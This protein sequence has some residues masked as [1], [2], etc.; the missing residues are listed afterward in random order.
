MVYNVEGLMSVVKT[1]GLILSVFFTAFIYS[2]KITS[3]LEQT[4]V[5]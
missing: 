4:V 3:L 1:G 2:L 5:T